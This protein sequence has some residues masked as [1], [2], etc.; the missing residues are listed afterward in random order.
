MRLR[1]SVDKNGQGETTSEE[2][3]KSEDG[4]HLHILR[5]RIEE[6]RKRKR[7]LWSKTFGWVGDLQFKYNIT[8]GLYMLD[9]WERWVFNFAA[10]LIFTLVGIS[11]YTQLQFLWNM[12]L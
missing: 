4:S 5:Q 6:D 9:P 2:E 12:F 1:S 11:A 8:L 10:L 7:S 3:V